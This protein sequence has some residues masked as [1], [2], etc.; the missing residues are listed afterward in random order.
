MSVSQIVNSHN[1]F[2]A[3]MTPSTFTGVEHDDTLSGNGTLT[4]P[5]GCIRV[6]EV[7]HDLTL[8]G[9]GTVSAPLGVKGINSFTGVIT[10]ESLTGDGYTS[11]LGLASAINVDSISA[12]YI[13]M[14]GGSIK[15]TDNE[16]DVYV[17]ATAI[18]NWNAGGGPG[19]NHVRHDNNLTGNGNSELLGL[20]SNV[21]FDSQY[22]WSQVN[23]DTITV[24]SKQLASA[25][26][27][28]IGTTNYGA[29]PYVKIVNSD[30][31]AQYIYHDD[32]S[33]W[34]NK[35]DIVTSLAGSVLLSN[36]DSSGW[37]IGTGVG[38]G[39]VFNY[40]NGLFAGKELQ[41]KLYIHELTKDEPS[42]TLNLSGL[43]YT[44]VHLT[45]PYRYDGPDPYTAV[46]DNKT[47]TLYSGAYCDLVL[48]DVEGTTKWCIK[49]SGYY[50]F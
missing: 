20:S 33:A 26:K 30:N 22:S 14:G 50:S 42:V 13:D 39:F 15:F 45:T 49:D 47:L 10:D 18:R 48:Q 21:K 11:A 5:L 34:N 37:A 27:V 29:T 32:I 2:L 43:G 3:R 40:G 31:D 25:A 41:N 7:V 38:S 8:S 12:N 28:Q 46:I 1:N 24:N 44:E 19:I 6:D 16:G 9:D 23:G 4:S 36:S 17:D 35:P